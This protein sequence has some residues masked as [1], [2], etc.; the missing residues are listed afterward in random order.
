M[1]LLEFD[2]VSFSHSS[3][4]RLEELSFKLE[5][6]ERLAIAGETGSGKT[7]IL[8]LVA[9]LLQP[10][11]GTIRLNGKPVEG[12]RT[13]LVPGHER[14]AYLS[15]YFEVQKFLRIEQVLAYASRMSALSAN[16]IYR[17]CEIDHLMERTTDQ[18]SGGERQRVALARL[19]V[20][21]PDLLL[22]DEPYSNLDSVHRNQMKSV[23][24]RIGDQL[25]ITSLLVSHDA[26][27]SLSWA[28]DILVLEHGRRVQQAAPEIIYRRPVSEYV[29]ALF[30]RYN[31]FP[32]DPTIP[33]NLAMLR[34]DDLYLVE[35]DPF[36]FEGDV[37]RISFN[38]PYYE[39]QVETPQAVLSVNSGKPS[40][41][42]GDHVRLAV[43]PE[44]V[45]FL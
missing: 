38:G 23:V 30:G 31:L 17:I 32:I 14:I 24:D 18:L 15:Q 5:E 6:G 16:R 13:K 19:L 41:A 21:S 3:G 27:D 1:A 45:H 9:G 12:P 7:T 43:V 34:P 29:A 37:L 4:F 8:K 2:R 26:T 28:Q 33:D 39:I 11:S 40:C 35:D 44:R 42:V 10:H 36:E 22:L 20:Q 25:G